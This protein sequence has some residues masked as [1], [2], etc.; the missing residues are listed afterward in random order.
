MIEE[1]QLG[2]GR[3][4]RGTDNYHDS[5]RRQPRLQP[6]QERAW[7]EGVLDHIDCDDQVEGPGAIWNVFYK[8]PLEA[9]LAAASVRAGECRV[10]T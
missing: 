7:T 8:A 3:F 1:K 4:S 2:V 6:G 10:D 9:K 5:G